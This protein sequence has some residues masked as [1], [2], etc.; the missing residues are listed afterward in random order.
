VVVFDVAMYVVFTMCAIGLAGC[1]VKPR[2]AGNRPQGFGCKP[3]KSATMVPRSARCRRCG[4]VLGLAYGSPRVR[5]SRPGFSLDTQ[6][7]PGL[8]AHAGK[9]DPGPSVHPAAIPHRQASPSVE[10][11]QVPVLVVAHRVTGYGLAHAHLIPGNTRFSAGRP[12][13]RL[14]MVH[15]ADLWRDRRAAVSPKNSRRRV[16]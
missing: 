15:Q 12:A 3:G 16:S 4:C 1:V 2:S 8:P 10:G 13:V 11:N 9:A 6:K 7:G 5:S 14:V